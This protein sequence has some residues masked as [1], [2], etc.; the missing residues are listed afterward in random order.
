MQERS[1]EEEE[2]HEKMKVETHAFFYFSAIASS[3]LKVKNC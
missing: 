1:G 2:L 3:N